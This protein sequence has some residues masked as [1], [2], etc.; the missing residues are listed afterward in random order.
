MWA[1]TQTHRVQSYVRVEKDISN[2]N[3]FYMVAEL[4]H[5]HLA[6]AAAHTNKTENRKKRM[7]QIIAHCM[8]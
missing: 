6:A 2:L 7:K 4:Y 3:T 8:L 1:N 5:N